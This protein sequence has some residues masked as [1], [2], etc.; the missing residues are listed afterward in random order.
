MARVNNYIVTPLRLKSSRLPEKVL[1]DVHGKA[2]CVR[3]LESIRHITPE[4][5]ELVAAIDDVRVAEAIQNSDVN[6]EVIMTPADCPSGTDRV[7]AACDILQRSESAL[8][9]KS[10]IVNIQGD[11]PFLNTTVMTEFLNLCRQSDAAY[12]TLAQ[13]WPAKLSLEDTSKVKCL[14]DDKSQ[15]RYFSRAPVPFAQNSHEAK[16]LLHIGVYAYQ[17]GYLKEFCALEP[18]PWEKAES[19]EQ[20]RALQ[21]G[22]SLYVHRFNRAQEH[23]FR[24]IDT[25]A[26]LNWLN[27]YLSDKS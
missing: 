2:L 26:D 1:A 14:S 19:L 10:R 23:E 4:D 13:D 8:V 20:L 25:L 3:V 7:K 15:A 18:S 21:A 24:G 16:P 5:F 12:L 17:Y 6:C 11:M 22:H 27:S 9:D